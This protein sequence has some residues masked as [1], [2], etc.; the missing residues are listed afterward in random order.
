MGEVTKPQVVT[1]NDAQALVGCLQILAVFSVLWM[2]SG[3]FLQAI[4][5]LM[6]MPVSFLF[7]IAMVVS[8]LTGAWLRRGTVWKG[9]IVPTAKSLPP[10]K[11]SA[12]RPRRQ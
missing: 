8:G 3:K 11:P 9:R 10:W 5:D 12:S 1:N 6:L 7:F 2:K 4:L